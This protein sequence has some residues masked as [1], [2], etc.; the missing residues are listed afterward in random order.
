ML[1][2]SHESNS[3][4]ELEGFKMPRLYRVTWNREVSFSCETMVVASDE[5]EAIKK[6]QETPACKLDV[7][8]A[9]QSE[10][11]DPDATIVTLEEMVK[12]EIEE[13]SCKNCKKNI[14]NNCGVSDLCSDGD[15]A[16]HTRVDTETKTPVDQDWDIG[17]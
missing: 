9:Y 15:L 11:N 8:E 12:K 3:E 6:A 16:G 17:V 4:I 7:Y 10:N 1:K 2:L 5:N 13:D 14:D